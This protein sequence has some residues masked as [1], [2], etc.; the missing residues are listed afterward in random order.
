[1]PHTSSRDG[2][3]KTKRRSLF[4]LSS[5]TQ[6][7]PTENGGPSSDNHKLRKKR[8]PSSA[9]DIVAPADL[10]RQESSSPSLHSVQSSPQK[11]SR[12]PSLSLRSNMHRPASVFG[13]LRSMRSHGDDEQPPLHP[14]KTHSFQVSEFDMST[15]PTKHV[16]HHGE[17]QTSGSMF[18]KKKE[19]LVLTD[20][21]IVRCKSHSKAAETFH[22]IPPPFG[23]SPTIRHSSSQSIGSTHDAQSFGSDSS[24]DKEGKIPLRQVVA[25]H[26]HEDGRPYFALEVCYMDEESNQAS[27]MTM[28][29]NHPEERDVW[30][31]LIRS[32]ASTM[33]SLDIKPISHYNANY[34]ART[35]ER[36]GDYDPSQFQ[37]YKVVQRQLP[38]AGGRSS[39]D[40]LSK[41][42][43]V[44]CFLAVG[45]HKVHLIPLPKGSSRTSSPALNQSASGSYG[46][47]TVSTIKVSPRDDMIE[48]T[49]RQPLKRPK[50]LY[51]ASLSSHDIALRIHQ[52][53][54]HLRPE[55]AHWLYKFA[56]PPEVEERA[57]HPV[58]SSDED[59]C[60]FERTLTAYCIAYDVNPSKIRYTINYECEDAP[61][62]ELLP[63]SESRKR[64]YNPIELLAVFRALRY[65]ESFGSISFADIN[66]D[67]LHD[68]N[69]EYGSEYV[70]VR[71]KRGTP[72][73]L[74]P[75]E[76]C[77][78]TLLIQEVRALASTSKR[79]RRMD[80]SRCIRIKPP[81]SVD[82]EG[83]RIADPGCGIVEA[84][85]PLC[86]HQTTNIDWISLNGIALSDTDLDYL[87]GAAVDRNCHFRALELSS[88]G[89]NDRTLGL[90]LDALRAHDNT[91]EALDISGNQARLSPTV[92]DGQI[93]VFGFIR[94]LDL[95][96]LP[97][98]S[99]S[100]PLLTADT[101]L[102]WRLEVLKLSGVQIN[103]RT[104]DA[105]ATYLRSH[106]SSTLRELIVDHAFLTGS[107]IAKLMDA[108]DT[109][110][111]EARNLHLDIS[112]NNI[113]R[114]HDKLCKAFIDCHSPTHVTLRAME[115][116][117]E[118]VLRHLISAFRQNSSTRYL[119]ISRASLP[120]DASEETSAALGRLFA[121]NNTLEE[122]DISGE[123]SRLETSKFG[124]GLNR[125]LQGLR[126]NTKLRVLHIQFQKLGLPGASTLAEVLKENT[127][128]RELHCSNN[129]I[130]LSAFTD[131]VNALHKNT[132]LVFLPM[133]DESRELALKQ[134]EKQVKQIR[135]EASLTPAPASP[136][137][138]ATQLT[139]RKGL[140]S[141][142][143]QVRATSASTPSFPS[144]S[145]PQTRS[146]S[147]PLTQTQHGLAP[148]SRLA[149]S[150]LPSAAPLPQLSEQDI[151]AALRLVAESWDRQQYRLQ[152]Y[153]H[154]NWALLQGM[155]VPMEIVEED[156]ERPDSVG[157]LGQVLER[158]KNEATPTAERRHLDFDTLGGAES[159]A[160]SHAG[161]HA[162]SQPSSNRGSLNGDMPGIRTTTLSM[163]ELIAQASRIEGLGGGAGEAASP[164]I[165]AAA[166]LS[167]ALGNGY[168]DSELGSPVS[169]TSSRGGWGRVQEEEEE[170]EEDGEVGG[171]EIHGLGIRDEGAVGGRTPTR[172]AFG[173]A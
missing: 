114:D 113:Y 68:L 134:T 103:E 56:V 143:R 8:A 29:F 111:G 101:L 63:I 93:S 19:Y 33:R 163:D 127:T 76:L 53:E 54:H 102:T 128:M 40:D 141:V 160:D 49:F 27:A 22:N 168:A 110:D 112:H 48:L 92:F 109:R 135:D 170:E 7:T 64:S 121:E 94:R 115:Y 84:L 97:R 25:V 95:S 43:S 96:N 73:K 119:D 118:T 70:C 30:L 138:K 2:H 83:V 88:C 131:L 158:V 162:G 46:I 133:M 147:S 23:R 44:V 35:V 98:T 172:E 45:I 144:L 169:P 100:E 9:S 24:G 136:L 87:V 57:A 157:S 81:E 14:T 36:E 4:A 55:C 155:D 161:S 86:R 130:P 5:L 117:D 152:Q 34:A 116:R 74:T 120:S 159:D 21:H 124:A 165:A 32:A 89:L 11:A 47:L 146:T 39:T 50:T 106:R 173:L 16:I 6:I 132:T 65:N 10:H 38:K 60:C 85:F 72:L 126:H 104:V 61:R 78:A 153:L 75:Q 79:L 41:I 52:M 18:R 123:D 31:R 58:D 13:S 20:T 66:L 1:M 108:M 69:D 26:A 151:L 148:K 171:L 17:V 77:R 139:M 122:L 156:F 166:A 37:L 90:V 154:R 149:N 142:K 82:D 80:F 107:D 71:T 105:L 150:S 129:D 67:S 137:T 62:F 91:L 28:Q 140:A 59:H 42:A 99:G 15:G 145:S 164:T 3:S 125:A 167:V 51:L 12:R